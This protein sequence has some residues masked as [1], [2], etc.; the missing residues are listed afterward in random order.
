MEK[1]RKLW[2]V[3]AAVALHATKNKDENSKPLKYGNLI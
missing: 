2:H 3:A 1:F